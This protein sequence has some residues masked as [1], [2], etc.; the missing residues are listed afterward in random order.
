VV[1]VALNQCIPSASFVIADAVFA[2]R[3]A[4]GLADSGEQTIRYDLDLKGGVGMT[5]A[6]HIARKAARLDPNP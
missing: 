5:D 6:V 3:S 4:G 1:N 2:L